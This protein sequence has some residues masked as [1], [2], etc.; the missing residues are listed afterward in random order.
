MSFPTVYRFN[1]IIPHFADYNISHLKEKLSRNNNV[2]EDR[3]MK[4]IIALVLV[5]MLAVIGLSACS[6][7]ET[8]TTTATEAPVV[9]TE[10]PV[11]TDEATEEPVIDVTE[12]P[13]G[14]ETAATTEG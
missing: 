12:A 4:K 14:D 8:T 13:A 11:A 2:W 9:E 10:A 6:N 5:M 3:S 1:G 7:K